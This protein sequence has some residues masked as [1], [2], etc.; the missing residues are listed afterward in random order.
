MSGTV[1]DLKNF[2]KAFSLD[3]KLPASCPRLA[4]ID[5]NIFLF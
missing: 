4:N 1:R 3:E 5:L 2:S